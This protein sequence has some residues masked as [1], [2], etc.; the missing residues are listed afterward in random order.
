MRKIK[1]F[2][3]LICSLLLLGC[4][5]DAIERWIDNPT[6]NDIK[7]VI[8]GEVLTIPAKSGINYTFE[9][10]KHTL[11]YNNDSFNFIVKPSSFNNSGFVNPTQS[12]YILYT[13]FYTDEAISDDKYHELISKD[14]HLVPVILN[15]KEYEMEL[16]VKIINDVFI[17]RRKN[18]WDYSIDDALP[19]HVTLHGEKQSPSKKIKL[20]REDEFVEFLTA[21]GLDM[22]MSFPYHPKK[23]DQLHQYVIPNIQLDEIKC[24][25]GRAFIKEQLANWHSLFVSKGADF[26]KTYE[27]LTSNQTFQTA[28][29]IIRACTKEKDK[30]QTYKK[31]VKLLES[32]FGETKQINF[33]VTE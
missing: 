29:A 10:G 20:Y 5:D 4:S 18:F 31:T 14:L 1:Y 30:N 12:N 3:I 17:E 26:V 25:K 27:K 6:T 16:S 13:I 19:E 33:I 15:G 32:T 8:D 24:D 2:S 7:V 21:D 28:H 23:F 22:A 9:Y 11:S